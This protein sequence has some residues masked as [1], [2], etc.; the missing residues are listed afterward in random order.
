MVIRPRRRCLHCRLFDRHFLYFLQSPLT[1]PTL[2]VVNPIPLQTLPSCLQ[3]SQPRLSLPTSRIPRLT[4]SPPQFHDTNHISHQRNGCRH[5]FAIQAHSGINFYSRAGVM[6]T[7]WSRSFDTLPTARTNSYPS[8]T[9]TACIA[10]PWCQF[11][12]ARF[13]LYADDLEVARRYE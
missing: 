3:F 8:G 7:T 9:R 2:N 5:A 4:F 12:E 11:S 10:Y 1:D 13:K 6:D